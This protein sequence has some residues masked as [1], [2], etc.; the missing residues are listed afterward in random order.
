MGAVP[1]KIGFGE[2]YS[3][4]DRGTVDATINHTP[5]VKSYK[6]CEVAG[7]LTEASMGQPLGYGG[8]INLKLFNK[9]PKNLQDILVATGDEYLDVYAEKYIADSVAAKKAQT[10]GIDGKKVRFYQLAPSERARWSAKADVFP[11]DWIAKME[12]KGLDAKGFIAAFNATRDKFRKE[13]KDKGYP[14]TR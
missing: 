3:A 7:H 14:W 13:L 5:F 11:T 4:L 8:G 6:H 2:L 10:A 9:M 1:V 12:K